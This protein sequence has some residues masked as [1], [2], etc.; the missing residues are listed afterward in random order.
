MV[1]NTCLEPGLGT[2]SCERLQGVK[3][4]SVTVSG[5]GD[6]SRNRAR[7]RDGK[8]VV[9][10]AVTPSALYQWE[11]AWRG[12]RRIESLGYRHGSY[13]RSLEDPTPF[14]CSISTSY[15]WTPAK[16]ERFPMVRCLRR[17]MGGERADGRFLG[18]RPPQSLVCRCL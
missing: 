12:S 17:E 2:V 7:A 6:S 13:Q 3:S 8:C 18:F 14:S 11:G 16:C 5:R 1:N 9:S 15:R 4:D 10:G